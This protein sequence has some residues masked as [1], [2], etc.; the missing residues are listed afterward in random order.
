MINQ[1]IL[2]C[3]IFRAENDGVVGFSLPPIL[4]SPREQYSGQ[5]WLCTVSY[6]T[7]M[8]M[9]LFHV[10]II[11]LSFENLFFEIGRSVC[12]SCISRVFSLFISVLKQA[13]K[14]GQFK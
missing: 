14:I 6:M 11:L 4:L 1:T 8:K 12:Y 9:W 7:Y 10:Y 2:M 5:S 3:V 13:V